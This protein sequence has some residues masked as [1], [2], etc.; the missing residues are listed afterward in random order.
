MGVTSTFYLS[1]DVTA[2]IRHIDKKDIFTTTGGTVGPGIPPVTDGDIGYVRWD[3]EILAN[4]IATIAIA[5]KES[6]ITSR[7]W[8]GRVNQ[9]IASRRFRLPWGIPLFEAAVLDQ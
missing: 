6:A 3:S 2:T 1:N 4:A 5:T 7:M 9:F 8:I